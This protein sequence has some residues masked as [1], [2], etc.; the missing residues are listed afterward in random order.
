MTADTD[1]AAESPASEIRRLMKTSD[2]RKA[3]AAA[4]DFAGKDA[5]AAYLLGLFRYTGKGTQTDRKAAV[6]E[7]GIAA[8]MGSAEAAIVAEEISRNPEDVQEK[9]VDL[10]FRAECGDLG[11]CREI[12]PLY[13]TGKNADG[14]KG[15][16]RKN[17]AEAVRLYMPC[18]DAGDA[19]AQN[20]I[21]YMYLMGKGIPKNRELAVKLLTEAWKNGSSQAAY[22]LAYMYDSGQDFN[23]PDL[24]RAYDWYTR[25]ADMG[26]PDAEFALAG[27]MFMQDGPY[28]DQARGNQLLL[29]AADSGQHEAEEQAGM[30]Y[31]YGGGGL[32]RD[33]A[34]AVKYLEAACEGGVQQAMTSYAN[35]CFE[36]QAVPRDLAK[37]AKWFRAAAD[38]CDGMAQYALGCMYGNGYYFEQD[39]AKAAEWFR[40][41]AEG[42]EPNAQ[43]ALGC[44]CYEGRGV[45]KD[46]KKAAAWFQEAAE[47]GHP[48]A[49]SF[50]GMFKITG[51]D[52]EQD[53]PEGLRLLK[54]AA[55]SGYPEAQFYLGKLYAEGEYVK[56]DL[57][58]AKKMLTAAAEQG[59]PDA[60]VMLRQLKKMKK[61][62]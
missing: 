61:R 55:G 35:M 43:Y 14:T 51:K 3:C 59:D 1:T 18:A 25:A 52:T 34:K 57:V 40:E 54:E 46:T 13:D 23:D 53:I 37:A 31:A 24:D 32:K 19:D 16:A 2:L 33:P 8:G 22:R 10:R 4:E 62:S 38:N 28:S 56:Q 9:L 47:Q 44:F 45:A 15:P 36:G 30:M 17:H 50:L 20:T 58:L 7:F 42:G 49:M 41:A 48:G 39:D 29:K 6:E 12:F 26:N 11:A 60:S 21:G 5:D 27:I